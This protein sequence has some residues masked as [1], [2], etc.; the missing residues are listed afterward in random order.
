[1]RVEVLEA[2]GEDDRER[3]DD[4]ETDGRQIAVNPRVI[5]ASRRRLQQPSH[6]GTTARPSHIADS[7]DAY[8][9]MDV[10]VPA[11]EYSPIPHITTPKVPM[12]LWRWDAGSL[13]S[14]ASFL[15]L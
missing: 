7:V 2:A 3:Q 15:A 10:L 9:S 11:R 8:V 5:D 13:L 1:M 12:M 4:P 6:G 14:K